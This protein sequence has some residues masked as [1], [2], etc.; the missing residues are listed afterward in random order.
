MALESKFRVTA[1]IE[2][3][4]HVPDAFA[5]KSGGNADSEEAKHRSA[6][7]E[8]EEALGGV[9][10]TENVTI[11]RKFLP[12]R[13]GPII[14]RIRPLRGRR[15]MSITVQPLDRDDNTIGDPDVY[16]GIFK[17]CNPSDADA[18][19]SDVSMFELE[20]STNSPIG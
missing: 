2:D 8:Q 6:G 3:Y 1:W 11:S 7:G 18:N 10:T 15:R 17:A 5:T 12:E 14:R 4:G 16:T 19:S 9:Q 13:D 20:L